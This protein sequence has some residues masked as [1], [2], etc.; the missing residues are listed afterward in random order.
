VGD[1]RPSRRATWVTVRL[2]VVMAVDVL[3]VVFDVLE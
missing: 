3:A 2:V 1:P